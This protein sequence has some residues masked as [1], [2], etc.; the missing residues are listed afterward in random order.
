MQLCAM[1]LRLSVVQ[2]CSHPLNF[3][4]Q[5]MNRVLW[6]IPALDGKLSNSA[7]SNVS[8]SSIAT[9]SSGR[10][11]DHVGRLIQPEGDNAT[12]V[13]LCLFYFYCNNMCAMFYLILFII[14]PAAACGPIAQTSQ[15]ITSLTNQ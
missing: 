13:E 15:N 4:V 2:M 6:G 14:V 11:S 12:V 1:L 8:S 9:T 3:V 5:A 7:R 10:V